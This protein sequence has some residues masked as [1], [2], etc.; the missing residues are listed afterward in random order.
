[1]AISFY[2]RQVIYSV[3]K[4]LSKTKDEDLDQPSKNK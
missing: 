3:M 1:M 2:F 4:E